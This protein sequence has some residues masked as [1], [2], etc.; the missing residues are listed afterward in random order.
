VVFAVVRYM[1]STCKV[2]WKQTRYCCTGQRR[3]S[4]VEDEASSFE[5][6]GK[7]PHNGLNIIDQPN[8]AKTPILSQGD[9]R[10]GVSAL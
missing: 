10:C 9:L 1:Y 8:N 3:S 7:P 5:P 6:L 2:R 4:Q